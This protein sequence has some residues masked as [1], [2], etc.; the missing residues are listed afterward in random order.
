MNKPP[1]IEGDEYLRR[2]SAAAEAA[3]EADYDAL[4]ICSRGGGTLDRYANVFYLSGFYSPFP[5]IP[6]RH[7]DWSARAH[8]FIVLPAEAHPVLVADVPVKGEAIH[9]RD[10]V[11]ADDVTSAVIEALRSRN[12]E[13]AR[14]GLVG[15]DTIP[16]K[17][18]RELQ[19]ALPA[20]RW[21]PADDILQRLRTIKSSSE[22]EILRQ[23]SAIGS[24]A[25]DGMLDY[26]KP[27]VTHGE[28]MA[29]GL[30]LMAREGAQLYNAFMSSGSGG[31]SPVVVSS[32]FPT[33]AAAEPLQTG[34][35]FHIGLS[36]VWRGYYFDHS[37]SMP[38]GD[39]TSAQIDVFEA[40]IESVYAGIDAVRPGVTAGRV[41]GA[42]FTRLKELG[43]S[44]SSEFSGLG[45]G[46]GVGWD[47]PWLM[48]D[49]T[50]PLGPGMVLC[51][52]RE[53]E[54][55]GCVGDFE[56]TVLVTEDGAELLTH[57][58]VRRW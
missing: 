2:Q 42:G 19:Q 26:A 32:N 8:P 29:V 49:D 4:L 37:R 56:E 34:Q 46:I 25:I 24:R 31:E 18:F 43:Y 9:I 11:V 22:I 17:V 6:D 16:W 23:A 14:I 5:Y 58:R 30:T 41:A 10:V 45:H 53:V 35:W 21:Q 52:E 36:G 55:G 47:D 54:A 1:A 3:S 33:F 44:P 51:I 15:S 40:A 13:G 50:T 27:G 39:P 12:L 48:P 7:P 57:A 38:V 28:V 20:V